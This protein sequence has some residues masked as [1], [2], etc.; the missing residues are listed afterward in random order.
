MKSEEI[1]ARG[2][3]KWEHVSVSELLEAVHDDPRFD[4]IWGVYHMRPSVYE[5]QVET[6][7]SAMKINVERFFITLSKVIVVRG[8]YFR[9][10]AYRVRDLMDGEVRR[11]MVVSQFYP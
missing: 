9:C 2:E 10:G 4:N 11:Y 5:A 1:V 3:T 6:T 8:L 7:G